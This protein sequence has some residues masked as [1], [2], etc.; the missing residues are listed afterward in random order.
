M[1]LK[2]LQRNWNKFGKQDPLYRHFVG[3]R[4]EGK[5]VETEAFLGA[6]PAGNRPDQG[7][8]DE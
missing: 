6:G 5:Q 8:H 1:N 2:E 4:Q 3:G 7:L